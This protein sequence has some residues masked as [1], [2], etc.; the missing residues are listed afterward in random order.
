MR[1]VCS[2]DVS[3]LHECILRCFEAVELGATIS[4]TVRVCIPNCYAGVGVR[5]NRDMLKV[6][7]CV[8]NA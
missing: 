4:N 8:N 7:V 3:I 6:C 2:S 5:V 1:A